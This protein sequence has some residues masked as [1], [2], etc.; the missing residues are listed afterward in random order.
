MR[1]KHEAH[2]GENNHVA[3][4][5]FRGIQAM[6]P[7][8]WISRSCS[9]LIWVLSLAGPIPNEK[10][11]LELLVLF[12]SQFLAYFVGMNCVSSGFF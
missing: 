4:A 10:S 6:D 5:V 11:R 8:K 2:G 7:L 12:Y 1:S 3:T 9:S